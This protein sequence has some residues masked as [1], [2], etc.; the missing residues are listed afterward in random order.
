M[1][2]FLVDMDGTIVDSHRVVEASW[3]DFAQ[4]HG[5]D[6]DAVIA[7]CHGRPGLATA[8]QFLDDPK[9]AAR[10]VLAMQVR[11]Q[12]TSEGIVEVP[13]A[14]AF[15]AAIPDGH[16][17][18]VTSAPRALAEVRLQQVG[19]AQPAVMVCEQDIT[20]GKPHPEPFL[21]GAR[22]LGVEAADCVVLEDS[23]AGIE[24]GLAAGCRVVA[25]GTPG[26]MDDRVL[27]RVPDLVGLSPDEF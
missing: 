13:G 11:E 8:Q 1:T 19:I 25:V 27:R 12:A 15:I 17:A 18:L 26:A 6:V 5:L 16:W 23:A 9:L 3:R 10:E 24:A 22:R 14:R 7:V 4:R 20:H 2:Y 21:L